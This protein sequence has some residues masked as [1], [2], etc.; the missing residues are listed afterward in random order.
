MAAKDYIIGCGLAQAYI[1][2]P[3]KR[4][5]CLMLSD[6][7]EITEEEILRLI[8]WYLDKEATDGSKGFTFDSAERKGFKVKVEFIE[9]NTTSSSVVAKKED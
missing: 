9:D 1:C 2:K 7:R 4:N 6:R 3:S 5:P 8:D